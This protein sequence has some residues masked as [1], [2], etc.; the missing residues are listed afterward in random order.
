M[1]AANIEL[2]AG[3]INKKIGVSICGAKNRLGPR[4]G[5]SFWF[6]NYNRGNGPLFSIRPSGFK[7]H[8][9]SVEFG[10]YAGPCVEHIQN[11]ATQEDFQLAYAFISH[12]KEHFTV[13]IRPEVTFT[14]REM[15]G[16]FSIEVTR[17]VS[18]LHGTPSIA[19]TIEMVM[20]P[21]IAAM[22][23]LIG[24]EEHSEGDEEN[25]IADVEGVLTLALIRKRERSPRNRWLCLALHG[26]VC[27]VC[28]FEPQN[29]YDD[30]ID[31]IIEVHHIE[32]LSE[33]A[34]PRSYDPK[35]DLI[36]L[37]PNCHRAIHK[38]KPAFTPSELKGLL[39]G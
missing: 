21:L 27:N 23:E 31:S 33:S 1:D 36:P 4:Q 28:G 38:R 37:C 17:T 19:E 24:Y 30:E 10:P 9:V 34:C 12:L 15:S 39:L 35:T 7:R 2:I 16:D 29:F 14:N 20:V 8:I 5:L 18:D 11:R 22:A 32:P 3:Q 25:D 26:D 6:E 13:A